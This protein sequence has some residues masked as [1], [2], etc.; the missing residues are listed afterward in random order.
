MKRSLLRAAGLLLFLAQA[1]SAHPPAQ[2]T[3]AYDK[4]KKILHVGMEHVSTSLR[5]HHIRKLIVYKNDQEVE[6]VNLVTQTTAS[7][8]VKD[9]TV[10]AAGGDMLSV[11]ALCSEGGSKEGSLTVPEDREEK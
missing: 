4:E 3:L 7:T 6:S 9:I 8:L 11:K 2:L 1:V 10:D 5:E